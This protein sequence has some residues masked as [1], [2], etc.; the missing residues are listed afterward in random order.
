ML[1]WSTPQPELG[2]MVVDR[3][4]DAEPVDDLVADEPR[5]RR[6]DLAWCW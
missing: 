3:A 2:D 5:V 1:N 4:E 6:A